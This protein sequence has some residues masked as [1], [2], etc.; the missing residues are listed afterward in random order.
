[1]VERVVLYVWNSSAVQRPAL[2]IHSP[3]NCR[4][5]LRLEVESAWNCSPCNMSLFQI[6]YEIYS[7]NTQIRFEGKLQSFCLSVMIKICSYKIVGQA[8]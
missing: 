2:V 5:V 7:V 8:N 4:A 1:M 6:K 3:P